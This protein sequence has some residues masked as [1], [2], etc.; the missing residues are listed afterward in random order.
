MCHEPCIMVL[1][2]PV[3]CVVADTMSW[4]KTDQGT[5]KITGIWEQL[6][7]IWDWRA[8]GTDNQHQWG[9]WCKPPLGK[10]VIHS[11]SLCRMGVD[12]R[13]RQWNGWTGQ[14]LGIRCHFRHRGMPP[15]EAGLA[16]WSGIEAL[17]CF[18]AFQIGCAAREA[19]S[20]RF[21]YS[22]LGKCS[23]WWHRHC[24]WLSQSWYGAEQCLID[25]SATL[26][27]AGSCCNLLYQCVMFL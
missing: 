12:F 16:R 18:L 19:V 8:V 20:W 3:K 14:K 21:R 5:Q 22:R 11:T 26:G 7:Q 17:D 23:I 9:L 4:T 6:C 25:Y 13:H 2:Y 10:C 27:G 24:F 15:P 1:D